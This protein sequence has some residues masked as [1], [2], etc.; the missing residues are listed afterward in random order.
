MTKCAI[1][2]AFFFFFKLP[3]KTSAL[4][5][6][7]NRYTQKHAIEE[8]SRKASSLQEFQMVLRNISLEIVVLPQ[9]W[10]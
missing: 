9:V 3:I 2:K 5:S 4:V 10:Q 7:V 6:T 8:P 1:K